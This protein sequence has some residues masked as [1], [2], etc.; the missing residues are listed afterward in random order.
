MG[1]LWLTVQFAKDLT[2]VDRFGRQD[3]Y[4]VLRVGGRALRT[5]VANK[6]GRNPVWNE[7]FELSGV[8]DNAVEVVIKDSN[9]VLSDKLIG[10]ASIPLEVARAKG[11]DAADIPVLAPGKHGKRQGH[12]T[13]TLQWAHPGQPRPELA[14][15]PAMAPGTATAA[16]QSPFASYAAAPPAAAPVVIIRGDSSSPYGSYS[17]RDAGLAAFG[18]GMMVGSAAAAR[19]HRHCHFSY[20]HHA[21]H[22][23][24]VARHHAHHHH[25][26]GHAHHVHAHHHHM[27]MAHGHRHH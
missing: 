24:H 19:R 12:L 18:M 16:T 7:T 14:P 21:H 9:R 23:A 27:G 1:S 15:A 3:P 2:N 13:V 5:R 6:A 17:N 11:F 25:H 8:I 4:C 26:V 22:A 20:M 10:T